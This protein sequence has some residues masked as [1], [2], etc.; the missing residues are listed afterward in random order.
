MLTER[1]SAM[2]VMV[3]FLEAG[4][5]HVLM[6]VL[7]SVVVEVGVLVFDVVVFVCGVCVRVSDSTVL[8]FV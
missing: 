7:S 4:L 6:G 2:R 1:P 3:N 8:V 5:M